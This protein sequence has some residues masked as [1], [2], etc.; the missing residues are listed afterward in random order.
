MKHT[1]MCL[2]ALL[3][4]TLFA[5]SSSTNDTGNASS[6]SSG[7]SGSSSGSS[8][9]SS[10]S[11]GSSGTSSGSSG[12]VTTEYMGVIA[13]AEKGVVAT[14]YKT[15]T[16]T[17][18]SCATKMGD[19]TLYNCPID[20]NAPDVPNFSAGDIT[21]TG[22]SLTAALVLQGGADGTSYGKQL[23]APAFTSGQT[24]MISA[25][26]GDVTAFSGNVSPTPADITITQ[27]AGTSV[28]GSQEFEYGT[29]DGTADLTVA[30]TGG[31]AGSKLEFNIANVD[32]DSKS[33]EIICDF[34][35]SLGTATIPAALMGGLGK[36]TTGSLS[37]FQITRTTVMSSNAT[38]VM[39]AEGAGPIGS[40]DIQ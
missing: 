25:A 18:T 32:D 13:V 3:P 16:P 22:G 6:S 11:S 21:I 26:G 20:P 31:T 5:C 23:D 10:G 28:G 12:T 35:A 37:A 7:S 30:W 33:L 40:F 39:S 34:D 24:L 2:A 17:N 29:I 27:P 9:S 8:G 38:V 1:L 4:L 15:V 14:F 19:C 36:V